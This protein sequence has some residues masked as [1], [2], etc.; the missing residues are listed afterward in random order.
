VKLRRIRSLSIWA[1]L[2]LLAVGCSDSAE[3]DDGCPQD[4]DKTAPGLCGCNVPDTDRDGDGAPDCSDGCP[5]DPAKTEPGACGCSEVDGDGDGTPDCT[6]ECPQDGAKATAGI[7]GCGVPETDGDTDGTPD[8]TDGCPDSAA[9]T[10]PGTCGCDYADADSDGDGS[11]DCDDLCPGFDDARDADGDAVPN[12]CDLDAG[13][14]SDNADC[15]DGLS[16]TANT[17]PVDVCQTRPISECDW[18]A[19]L[20]PNATNLTH[21]EGP[22]L[23]NDFGTDLSGAVYNPVTRSLWLCRNGGPSKIWV[24]VEDGAGSFEIGYDNGNRGEWS[25]FGDLE[26]LTF[27]DFNDATTLY[28]MVEGQERIKEVDLST[29]G[30]AVTNNDWDTSPHL[31]LAGGSG[32]EG[33]TFVPDSYLVAQ[34]FVDGSGA[35]YSSTGGMGGLMLAGHQNGGKIYAFDLDRTDSSFT[36]VGEYLTSADETAALEFDRST[37]LLYIWHGAGHNTLEVARLSSAIA[38]SDRKLDT[39][40]THGGPGVVLFGSDNHEG[41]ALTPGSPC[42]TGQRDLFMTTDGGGAASLLWYKQFPCQ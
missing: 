16:C 18:P 6:D 29:Y 28:L 24:A 38:G 35:A 4:P 41:I 7:C 15:D 40:K 14:C 1:G 23:D 2:A 22:I 37:G 27:A 20:A 34:G 11:L 13:A 21:I 26:G 42:P 36:F 19:E 8:C 3:A 9:K 12:G 39:V 25:D 30:T 33:I 17:C 10:E 32:A 5:D 31:P